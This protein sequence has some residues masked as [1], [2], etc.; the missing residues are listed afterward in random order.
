ML[1][2]TA[3]V[4][5]GGLEGTRYSRLTRQRVSGDEGSRIRTQSHDGVDGGVVARSS[6]Q[7]AVTI[8]SYQG[9]LPCA[10]NVTSPIKSMFMLCRAGVKL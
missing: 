9:N 8:H 2:D 5:G 4:Y 1:L 6:V 10:I 3:E 7:L